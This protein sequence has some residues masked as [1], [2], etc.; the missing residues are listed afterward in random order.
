M[1]NSHLRLRPLLLL[2]LPVAT[3]AASLCKAREGALILLLWSKRARRPSVRRPPARPRFLTVSSFPSFFRGGILVLFLCGTSP[4]PGQEDGSDATWVHAV[5]HGTDLVGFRDAIV[6]MA[7]LALKWAIRI[8]R[9]RDTF[10]EIGESHWFPRQ[11]EESLNK[12]RRYR[13]HF[14]VCPGLESEGMF[15]GGYRRFHFI[16]LLLSGETR[17]MGV[18]HRSRRKEAQI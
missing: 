18:D 14:V 11:N 16:Y 7:R 12:F 15:K 13:A 4:R 10:G 6:P 1:A 17:C 8:E 2:F 9:K 3:A 5:A